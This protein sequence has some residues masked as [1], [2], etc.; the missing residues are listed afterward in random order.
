VFLSVLGE[1]WKVPGV[2]TNEN[3]NKIIFAR[4]ASVTFCRKYPIH[5]P[6]YPYNS[7]GT[8]MHDSFTNIFFSDIK[9]KGWTLRTF[10]L[11]ETTLNPV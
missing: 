6:V 11:T 5:V 7:V 1:L 8:S 4:T 9:L 3:T 10:M 2:N